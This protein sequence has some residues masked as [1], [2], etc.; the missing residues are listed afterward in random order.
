MKS[1]LPLYCIP[2]VDQ[3]KLNDYGKRFSM[4]VGDEKTM[5]VI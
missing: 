5:A 2:L 4:I 3:G 1:I